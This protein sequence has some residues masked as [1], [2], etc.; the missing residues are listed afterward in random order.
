MLLGFSLS[1]QD[2]Y[3]RVTK[4]EPGSTTAL[5]GSELHHIR[6]SIQRGLC[7]YV[8]AYGSMYS[9]AFRSISSPSVY[10]SYKPAV[11]EL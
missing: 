6:P 1:N 7:N 9:T 5:P 3:G 4:K 2:G 10:R 11:S 8:P